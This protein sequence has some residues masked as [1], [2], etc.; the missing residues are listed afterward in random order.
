[1]DGDIACLKFIGCSNSECSNSIV[2]KRLS[3]V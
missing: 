2:S 3:A 1:M